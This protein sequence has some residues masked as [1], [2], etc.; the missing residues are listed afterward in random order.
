MRM[1]P[2]QQCHSPACHSIKCQTGRNREALKE[3]LEAKAK[4]EAGLGT[5]Y[6][7][8]MIK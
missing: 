6:K 3:T 1:R 7:F 4:I 2:I 5:E 8:G